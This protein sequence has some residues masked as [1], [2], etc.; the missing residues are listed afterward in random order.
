[1]AQPAKS[2]P[3]LFGPI[4]NRLADFVIRPSPHLFEGEAARFEKLALVAEQAQMVQAGEIRQRLIQPAIQPDS[5]S[6]N[7]AEES[8]LAVSHCW[9][10]CHGTGSC[11]IRRG[12]APVHDRLQSKRYRQVACTAQVQSADR[13][14]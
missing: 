8:P 5:G 10:P 6:V 14:S 1:M 11:T 9:A 3:V 4:H 7:L 12:V 13:R 2:D